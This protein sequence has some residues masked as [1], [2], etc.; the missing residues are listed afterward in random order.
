MTTWTDRLYHGD[1]VELMRRWADAGHRADLIV[2]DP[3]YNI[4]FRYDVYQ[5]N[6]PD[7]EYCGWTQQWMA[8]AYGLLKDDGTFWVAIG[9]EYAAEL[10]RLAESVGFHIRNWVVWYYT[11]GVHCTQMFGRSHTHFLYFVKDPQRFTFNADAVRVPSA[12]Q[13]VYNDRRADARGRLP[14]N[15]WILRPHDAPQAFLPD[16][17]TWYFARVAGTFRERAGFHGCQLPERLLER[18]IRAC[19][20]EGEVVVDPFAG[21]GSTLVVAKK[22][23]RRFVGCDLS[24]EYVRHAQRR[25]E[26]TRCGDRIEGP[27][28][29]VS[30]AKPTP[31][32][33]RRGPTLENVAVARGVGEVLGDQCAGEVFCRPDRHAGFLDACSGSDVPG[34][35]ADWNRLLVRAALERESP[36]DGTPVADTV[37]VAAEMA[38]R[39][40]AERHGV[41][42]VDV[43]AEPSLLAAFEDRVRWLAP[44]TRT[45][46]ARRAALWCLH[47]AAMPPQVAWEQ[48]LD[49]MTARM[50][51]LERI[52]EWAGSRGGIFALLC[53]PAQGNSVLHRSTRSRNQLSVSRRSSAA[54]A[55]TATASAF[56]S[57]S[58]AAF[59]LRERRAG[60][61][62]KAKIPP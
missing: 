43:L 31:R 13:L 28:D 1:C 60:W 23:R 51:E 49:A 47:A 25:L 44:G 11:F 19:S 52:A 21:S 45:E 5:D 30:S 22:L 54:A 7:D 40:L 38:L 4:G 32:L 35:T 48:R 42:A 20:N 12:R 33:Q 14:D 9:D 57:D 59:R 55:S 61:H 27:E 37:R 29:P 39:T 41:D 46:A 53:Q 10:K 50:W 8:A 36:A 62:N 24:E 58:A 16:H 15:T 26:S 2:A 6:L 17:D 3:P 56:P 34:R 18:I